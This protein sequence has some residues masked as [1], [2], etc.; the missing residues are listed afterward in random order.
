MEN[1]ILFTILLS[2]VLASCG[3]TTSFNETA[4]AGDSV[5]VPVG[6]QPNFSKDNITVTITPSSGPDIIYTAND[7]AIRAIIN[8]YPDPVSNMLVSRGIGE[9][10]SAFASTYATSLIV[11][12][13]NDK[14]WYQTTVFLDL[15]STLPTGT[16]Q[17]EINNGLGDTHTVLLDIIPG[18]GSA[19]SF[20]S[21]FNGGLIINADILDSLA[22]AN[23]TI[24]NTA[25][26]TS[27]PHAIE[28]TLTHNPDNTA[29]GTGKAFV[30]NPLGYLKTVSWSDDGT[31]MKII[32][33]QSKDGIID[34]MNDYKFYVAGTTTNLAFGSVK[35]YDVNGNDISGITTTLVPSN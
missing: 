6:M 24:I 8:L 9:D 25:S 29:G 15:P 7:S 10:T 14:D 13:N 34:D 20:N 28:I 5:A 3:G 12:A 2:V 4:R 1:K 27:I 21:D 11:S 35:G 26:A 18:I 16:T 32:L 17:I 19:H 22:R 33:M 30:V 31:N 23:H